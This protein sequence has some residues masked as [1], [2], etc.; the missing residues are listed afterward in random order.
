[1]RKRC[2]TTPD[3]SRFHAYRRP[4]GFSAFTL[5]SWWVALPLTAFFGA[6]Q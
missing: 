3:Q 1:M 6:L 2:P 5:G 4:P